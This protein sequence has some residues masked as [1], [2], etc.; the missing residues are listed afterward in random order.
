[1]GWLAGILGVVGFSAVIGILLTI[2]VA[3]ALA[4]ASVS[5][6]SAI[7]IFDSIPDGFDLDQQPQR[8]EIYAQS[9]AGNV[10]VATV[11]DQNRQEV[12][13]DQIAQAAL[14]AVVAGEDRR[15]YEHGGVDISGIIRA[16]GQNVATGDI[17]SGASTITQQLVKQTF[18]QQALEAPTEE[19]RD[20]LYKEATE[21]TLDRKVKEMRYAIALEKKYTKDEILTAYLNIANFGAATYGIEAASQRYFGVHASQ[22]SVAQAASLVAIVQFP[23]QRNL[24]ISA[25]KDAEAK[26]FKA[27]QDR[28]GYILDNMLGEGYIT[29][30]QHDEAAAIPVDEAFVANGTVPQQGCRTADIYA[31]WMCDYVVKS[32]VDF[33]FLGATPEERQANWKK[34]GYK[35]YTSLDYDANKVAT[36][37]L[38]YWTPPDALNGN[39]GGTVS[40]IEPGTGRIRVMAENKTF[41]DA[42][43]AEQ[44]DPTRS[45]S[46]N[47]NTPLDRGGSH[48][49]T[50]GSTYKLFT[51]VD[52]LQNG[53]GIHEVLSAN[54]G[55]IPAS[56]W[57]D[58]CGDWPPDNYTF[59][60]DAHESGDYT[61]ERG[62][63][64]SVNGVF[65]RMATK[66]DL[67]EIAD[68]AASMGAQ[69][70]D[71]KPLATGAS[72]V[73]GSGNNSVAMQSMADSYATI[74]ANGLHC[75]PI[76]ID[77][78]TDTEGVNH[79]GQTPTC[80]QAVDPDIAATVAYT[81]SGT[82]TKGTGVAANPHDGTPIFM[83]TGTGSF[84]EVR[85]VAGATSK[86]A[87][88]VW[89]GYFDTMLNMARYS[90]HG[91]NGMYLRDRIFKTVMQFLDSKY[92]G[93][94]FPK[95]SGKY[96]YGSSTTIPNVSGQG[97]TFDQASA[98]L[99]A[100]GFQVADGGP[101]DSDQA[102][103]TIAQQ[104]PAGGSKAG[105]GTTITLYESKQ[106]MTPVPDVTGTSVDTAKQTLQSKGWTPGSVT[107][108]CDSGQP[109]A[110]PADGGSATVTSQDPAGGS[111][112]AGGAT[113]NL[114]AKLSGADCTTAPG[115]GAGGGTGG[116]GGGGAGG[117]GGGGTGG[118][119]PGGGH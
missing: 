77:S 31:R 104:S 11:Y 51:L 6:Q 25:D 43:K 111:L 20:K 23:D 28:R 76:I 2:S 105:A 48:G 84:N 119:G 41:D 46:V 29:Q 9:S 36:D 74:A 18:V 91:V 79:P 116:T 113:V 42:P 8:N 21:P 66:L 85:L 60:N 19:E 98:I 4:L 13:Y 81:M 67:C 100:L 72:E 97:L 112:A 1:L 93:D 57:T 86:N 3:P 37:T 95:P 78:Y 55:T 56:A 92:G 96:Q 47:I 16:A 27:N 101:V 5:A 34:G 102:R 71:G 70:A 58:S 65:L 87:T 83:K 94:A 45:S 109:V 110:H 99:T 80:N 17:E 10:L 108:V 75:E 88:I 14:Q 107:Y 69:R 35:L 7:G 59:H 15:F 62:T 32:V 24:T 33:A 68:V 73:I 40:T 90:S 12:S 61:V 30:A 117:T 39:I 82:A 44:P 118:G 63:W 49:K 53:H 22:L 114:T 106:N 50:P 54:E 52:W 89:T 26:R 38:A 103:N 64:N 115:G